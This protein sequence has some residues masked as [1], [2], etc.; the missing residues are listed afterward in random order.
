MTL[1]AEHFITVFD[2]G[3]RI[4][5]VKNSSRRSSS[6][7]LCLFGKGVILSIKKIGIIPYFSSTELPL[8]LSMRETTF[9]GV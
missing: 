4:A 3:L 5:S 8:S 6:A 7:L 2:R 9:L 1:V